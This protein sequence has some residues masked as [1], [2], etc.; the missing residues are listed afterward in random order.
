MARTAPS[1]EALVRPLLRPGS[2]SAWGTLPDGRRW[3]TDYAC[4]WGGRAELLNRVQA[5][6]LGVVGDGRWQFGTWQ[7][8]EGEALDRFWDGLW[9]TTPVEDTGLCG[10]Q[11]GLAPARV[12]WV[13][14]CQ[15]YVAIAETYWQFL[16]GGADL[17]LGRFGQ[18][19][20]IFG[21]P[22]WDPE[23]FVIVLPLRTSGAWR[24]QWAAYLQPA[25]WLDEEAGR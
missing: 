18:Q 17:R 24:P 23:G 8:G 1:L 19:G 15:Q 22:A 12:L 6:C 16:A 13:P 21:R 10:K 9:P 5:R 25:G 14:N 7:A 20:A 2:R 11:E 3:G 4:L